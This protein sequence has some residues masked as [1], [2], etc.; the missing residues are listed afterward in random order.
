[1]K[2]AN[3]IKSLTITNNANG[4]LLKLSALIMVV[5]CLFVSNISCVKFSSNSELLTL[6]LAVQKALL[7]SDDFQVINI[8]NKIHK[9]ATESLFYEE[10]IIY[11]SGMINNNIN[12]IIKKNYPSSTVI[13]SIPLGSFQAKGLA[14]CGNVLFNLSGV[15]K[16]I[17]KYTYPNLDILSPL[18][19]DEELGSGEGLA[20]LGDEL[21]I[22]S[23][24]SNKIF[25]LDC[26]NELNVIKILD[27]TDN[28]GEPVTGLKDLVV[29]GDYIYA[30]KAHDIR[31]IKIEASTGKVVKIYNMIS[32]VNYELKA[33][34]IAQKDISSGAALLS[35]ITYDYRRKV[36]IITGKN[37]GNYYEIELK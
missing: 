22:A 33:K 26:K 12:L 23:N 15:F 3:P 4:F 17:F 32:L 5:M 7:S 9:L 24:G 36:F 25:I 27:I 10:G 21:L 1:M 37:W 30:N 2:I 28:Q 35:G 34:N 11:E 16:R 8:F 19:A 18:I 6:N 31:L 14:K 29:V 20:R 13:K